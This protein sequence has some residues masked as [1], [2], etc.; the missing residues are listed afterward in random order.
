MEIERKYEVNKLPGD[1]SQYKFKKIEQ[2]YLCHNPTIRIRKS[3]DDYIL[4]Y[5]SKLGL[6][7]VEEG[8]A[9]IH[10]EVEL[11]LTQE[12]F[13][14]LKVKTDGNFITKTRYLIP[15]ENGLTAELDIF[16][17]NLEGLVFAE[18]EFPDE[19]TANEFIPPDWFGR[20]LT[21]DKRF[22]NYQLSKIT[23]FH[24]LN[25]EPFSN[26]TSKK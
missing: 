3:N 11:P 22:S 1:L 6:Q 23:G 26:Q 14:V 25:L 15:I 16:K 20:E 24:E 2:G 9:L 19:K 8:S 12:A 4:T 18:V 21:S 5:K 17:D 7:K 10:H 13:E